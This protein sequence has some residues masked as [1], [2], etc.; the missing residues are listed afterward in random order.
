MARWSAIMLDDIGK[1][2][3][4]VT[5]GGLLLLHGINKLL[6]GIDAIET[7]LL[8]HGVPAFVAYGVFV[9]EIVAPVAVIVGLFARIG[10]GVMVINMLA[11]VSLM[12]LP[13]LTAINQHGGY[14]LELQA[15]YLFGSL[16]VVLLGAGRMSVGGGP[17]N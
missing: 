3:L 9:G 4:R 5:V 11:A 16:A 1:L 7:A 2:V 13:D 10:A 6:N 17:L 14:Q 15:F 8:A 12:H